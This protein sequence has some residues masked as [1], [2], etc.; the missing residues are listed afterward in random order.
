[1]MSC[2]VSEKPKIGPAM[3]QPISNDI[4]KRKAQGEPAQFA[5]E[6]ANL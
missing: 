3:A 1:M 4:D 5:T 6:Q 2:H